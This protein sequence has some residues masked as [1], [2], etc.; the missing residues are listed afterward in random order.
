MSKSTDALMAFLNNWE[1]LK[2]QRPA[3]GD[4]ATYG[5]PLSYT[6]MDELFDR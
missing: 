5:Y 4:F 3:E 1:Q 6:S 2:K